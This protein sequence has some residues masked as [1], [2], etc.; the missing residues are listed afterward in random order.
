LN[1][2]DRRF[3]IGRIFIDVPMRWRKMEEKT[4]ELRDIFLSVSDDETVTESQTESH[5][6]L[7]DE[8]ESVERRLADVVETVREK[9]GFETDLSDEQRRQLI[10][11][12]YDGRSDAALAAALDCDEATVFAARMELHLVREDEPPLDEDA[13]DVVREQP[14]VD[15]KVLAEE[16]DV[17]EQAVDRTRT[18]LA[19]QERSRRVSQRFVTAYQ[20]ILTDA[21]LTDQFA[22]NPQE[23]GL[24][25]ATEGAETNVEF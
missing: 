17:T 2:C 25:G 9:F 19:T 15:A 3:L 12:F 4:E 23:D 20:E 11:Q 6:S 16:L 1:L 24:D 18:V 7:T 8:G 21:E 13:L 5:G 14:D 22:T 10:E